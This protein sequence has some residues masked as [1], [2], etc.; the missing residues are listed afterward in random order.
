MGRTRE[1]SM[2]A[3]RPRDGAPSALPQA[4]SP[5]LAGSPAMSGAET[6]ALAAHQQQLLAVLARE[7]RDHPGAPG[8]RSLAERFAYGMLGLLFPHFATRAGMGSDELA[9]ELAAL[10]VLLAGCSSVRPDG[11]R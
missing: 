8:L 5:G 10:A 6:R 4:A 2:A 9:E 3:G 7:H 11:A 1:A